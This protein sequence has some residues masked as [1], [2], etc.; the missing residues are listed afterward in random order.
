MKLPFLIT[1]PKSGEKSVSLTMMV[2]AYSVLMLWLIFGG[3]F[4]ISFIR[5]FDAMVF[6]E[7]FTPTAALYFGNKLTPKGVAIATSMIGKAA[8]PKPTA[9]HPTDEQDDDDDDDFG[10]DENP[11]G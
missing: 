6:V 11:G 3:V 7:V 9:P 5:E 8:A 10:T 2:V 1:S 4:N